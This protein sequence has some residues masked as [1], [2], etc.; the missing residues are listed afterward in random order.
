MDASRPPATIDDDVT[1]KLNGDV[2]A[3][4]AV[5]SFADHDVTVT[6]TG[7]KI[8]QAPAAVVNGALS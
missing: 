6:S 3:L 4:N 2:T 7:S 5:D 1:A 8:S